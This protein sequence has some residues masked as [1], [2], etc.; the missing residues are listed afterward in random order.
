M[1]HDRNGDNYVTFDEYFGDMMNNATYGGF[2]ELIAAG[3]IFPFK[4]E[5]YRNGLIYTESG[6]NDYPMAVPG[7]FFW[8]PRLGL[9]MSASRTE[10]PL[11]VH[12][13]NIHN[14]MREED[15]YD[16]YQLGLSVVSISAGLKGAR[17]FSH[18]NPTSN[19]FYTNAYRWARR[20]LMYSMAVPGTFFWRPRLGL[21]LSI[22]TTEGYQVGMSVVALAA[23]LTSANIF[24]HLNPASAYFYTNAYRWGLRYLSL[25][26]LW[27]GGGGDNFCDTHK[28]WRRRFYYMDEFIPKWLQR[29]FFYVKESEWKK[30]ETEFKRFKQIAEPE[31]GKHY[32]YP[33]KIF[34]DYKSQETKETSWSLGSSASV[35]ITA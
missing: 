17:K 2:C 11:D 21:D 27:I 14:I 34:N 28:V 23:G 30:E 20:Y 25:V 10:T 26:P 13:P 31:F 6:S 3:L 7:T 32:R 22:P 33:S 5:V 29:A 9:D 35:S 4:F 15:L 24:L 1:T 8:R 12:Q 19:Y 16:G 18:L